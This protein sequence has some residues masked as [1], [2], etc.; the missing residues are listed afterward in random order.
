MCCPCAYVA[1]VTGFGV[2]MISERLCKWAGVELPVPKSRW[3]QIT[4]NVATG[5]LAII[6]AVALKVFQGVS[7]CG[8]GGVCPLPILRA[9]TAS[10]G[11]ALVYNI[12]IIYLLDRISNRF[13]S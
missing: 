11:I 12:G 3:G 6:T 1:G 4:A 13:S 10:L 8:R 7:L 5:G 9:A 2:S